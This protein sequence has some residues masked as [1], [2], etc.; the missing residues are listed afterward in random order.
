MPYVCL[1]RYGRYGLPCKHFHKNH[2]AQQRYGL[3]SYAECHSNRTKNV[4]A[5][6]VHLR[7]Q[8]TYK[9]QCADLHLT[10]SYSINC[11][12]HLRHRILTHIEN[13]C[14][15]QDN[16]T[17]PLSSK[18]WLSLNHFFYYVALCSCL[19]YRISRK[20]VKK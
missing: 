13:K 16:I 18:I 20:S 2:S 10:H 17:F 3:I 1:R 8:V 7:P 4:K 11:C 15:K 12:G 19:P 5:T 9:F 14:I 6:D